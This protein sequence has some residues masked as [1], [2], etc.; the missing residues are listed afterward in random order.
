M[1]PGLALRR[2]PKR[3]TLQLAGS[4][5]QTRSQKT[6]Y[7]PRTTHHNSETSS[8]TTTTTRLSICP[9]PCTRESRFWV[10]TVANQASRNCP[11]SQTSSTSATLTAQAIGLCCTQQCPEQR[12]LPTTARGLRALAPYASSKRKGCATG[13]TTTPRLRTRLSCRRSS[14]TRRTTRWTRGL[15]AF[16]TS[17]SSHPCPT[18]WKRREPLIK[19]F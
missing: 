19:W 1:T 2:L 13:T 9:G 18:S 16:R 4:R 12:K 5:Q 11:K 17:V 3:D 10:V 6:C 8:S 7:C 14:S 15:L